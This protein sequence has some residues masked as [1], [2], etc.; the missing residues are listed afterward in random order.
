MITHVAGILGT[1][2]RPATAAL[3]QTTA[4]PRSAVNEAV[5]RQAVEAANKAMQSLS[6]SLEFNVDLKS[7]ETVV[8]VVDTTTQRLIRQIP[9][10][11]MLAIGRAL[12]RM[13]GLLLRS[14]A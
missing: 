7:G 12:D 11:E 4:A 2:A 14:K 5:V 1:E 6:N 10:E 13:Q 3:P 9:S 8:R